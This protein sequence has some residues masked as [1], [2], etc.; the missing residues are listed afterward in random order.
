MA[1]LTPR[2]QILG[3]FIVGVPYLVGR[4]DAHTPTERESSPTA[5]Q[6]ELASHLQTSASGCRPLEVAT[7]LARRVGDLFRTEGLLWATFGER[8]DG[9]NLAVARRIRKLRNVSSFDK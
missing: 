6:S 9:W 5:A 4:Y 8:D 2:P 3:S 1:E 7:G